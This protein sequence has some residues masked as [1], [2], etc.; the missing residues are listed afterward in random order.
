MTPLLVLLWWVVGF[1]IVV[2]DM[3]GEMDVT[4]GYLVFAAC[5]GV[6]GPT[7]VWFLLYAWLE[8]REPIVVIKRRRGRA[9]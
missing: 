9:S 5:V 7:A 4:L 1:A 3:S 8:K 2:W 6:M